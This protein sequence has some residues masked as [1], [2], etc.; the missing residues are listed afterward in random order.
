[1]LQNNKPVFLGLPISS[2]GYNGE[3]WRA[4]KRLELLSAAPQPRATLT[5]ERKHFMRFLKLSINSSLLRIMEIYTNKV[6]MHSEN[7]PK[8]SQNFQVLV[9]VLT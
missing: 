9:N 4:L 7:V 2:Y 6:N 5:C 3:V 8:N 1:M